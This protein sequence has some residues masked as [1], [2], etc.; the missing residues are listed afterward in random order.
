MNSPLE[1]STLHYRPI[2]HSYRQTSRLAVLLGQDLWQEQPQLLP[3]L[4]NLRADHHFVALEL[5]LIVQV[6]LEKA[7]QP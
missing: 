3:C 1:I 5:A 4:R 7:L 6:Q 2:L